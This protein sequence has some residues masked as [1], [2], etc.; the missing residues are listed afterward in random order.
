VSDLVAFANERFAST[1]TA[2]S[3]C[4]RSGRRFWLDR[5]LRTTPAGN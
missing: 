2:Y 5:D 3:S 1:E 4:R